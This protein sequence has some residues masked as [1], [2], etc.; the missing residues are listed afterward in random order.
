M[1]FATFRDCIKEYGF[2]FLLNNG[3]SEIFIYLKNV[4]F[5]VFTL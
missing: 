2:V 1:C 3:M 5:D 4:C